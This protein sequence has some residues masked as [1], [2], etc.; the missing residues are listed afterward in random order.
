[1]MSPTAQP[2]PKTA[3]L[4]RSGRVF[5][6]AAPTPEMVD[7]S[8][9]AWSLARTPRF[10]GHPD[11]TVSVALH[12]MH[13]SRIAARLW[14]ERFSVP[15]PPELELQALLHDAPEAYI[16]D[17]ISPLKRLIGEALEA[18]EDQIWT[19]IAAQFGVPYCYS[20][21]LKEADVIALH[22]EGAAGFS[23]DLNILP[24][25]NPGAE[26]L[27]FIH[28]VKALQAQLPSP[29]GKEHSHANL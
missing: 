23:P 12:S 8:D 20:P 7:L 22:F 26:A 4:T 16:G 24:A 18:I 13:V 28:R 1:M 21:V 15:M 2:L 17:V 5:D 27:E 6:L 9:I 11:C 19:V 25:H 10:N 3:M 14:Q 29:E